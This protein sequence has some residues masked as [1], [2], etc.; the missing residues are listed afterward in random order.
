[1]PM[2]YCR[3]ADKEDPMERF[4]DVVRYFLAGWHLR[5]KVRWPYLGLLTPSS[6]PFSLICICLFSNIYRALRNLTI[7]SSASSSAV[8]ASRKIILSAFTYA[9]RSLTIHQLPLTSFPALKVMYTCRVRFGP[10]QPSLGTLL[11]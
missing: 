4:I 7:L 3:T 2:I 5:P 8:N 1:M 11:L 9:N 10:N 6:F